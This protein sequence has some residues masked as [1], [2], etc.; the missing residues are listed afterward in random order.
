MSDTK[1]LKGSLFENDDYTEKPEIKVSEDKVSAWIIIPE[2]YYNVDIGNMLSGMG[3]VNGIDKEMMMELTGKMNNFESAKGEY[4]IAKGRKAVQGQPGELILRTN[5]PED[6]I[7]SSEDLTQVDYKTYRQKKLAL[8]EKD[9][10]VAMVIEPTDGRDGIDIFGDVIEGEDGEGVELNLGENVYVDG[11]KLVSKIDGLIEYKKERDGTISFDIAEVYLVNGDLDYSTGNVDFPGSVI[12]KGNI[13][14]GFQVTAGKDVIAETVR[15]RVVAGGSVVV[16]QG[17]I[18]ASEVAEVEAKSAVYAKFVQNAK[19]ISDEDVTIKKSIMSSEIYSGA[20]ISIE[21]SPGTIIGGKVV[22]SDGIS[23]KVIG[24][25]SFVKTEVSLF[26]SASAI[27]Q[28]K[29]MIAD[30]YVKSKKLLRIENYLGENKEIIKTLK[31]EKRE[32]VEKL[33]A[34]RNELRRELT[35]IKSKIVDLQHLLSEPVS[36]RISISKAAWPEVKVAISG[37]FVLL[38]DKRGKGE[39]FLDSDWDIDFR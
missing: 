2:N 26:N 12:V 31:G 27:I 22:A 15:G 37:R 8:A 29:D 23:A 7:L 36:G 38:K 6:I 14:A 35:E 5:K 20:S 33:I 9:K 34:H 21:G 17:I 19:I 11:R 13:K 10:P 3:I 18:G 16:K 32:S 39:F 28:L 4:L 1:D 25:E 24:S 30:K